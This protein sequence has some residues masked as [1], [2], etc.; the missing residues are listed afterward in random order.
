MRHLLGRALCRSRRLRSPDLLCGRRS[1]RLAR[2]FGRSFSRSIPTERPC[3]GRQARGGAYA[4][5]RLGRIFVRLAEQPHE[6]TPPF[7]AVLGHTVGTEAR[8]EPAPKARE[9]LPSP[10][11]EAA[12]VP[13]ARLPVHGESEPLADLVLGFT[14]DEV[15]AE[16]LEDH[17]G[18]VP[19]A[20]VEDVRQDADRLLAA[21]AEEAANRDLGVAAEAEYLPPVDA[22]AHDPESLGATSELATAGAEQWPQ[23]LDA[24]QA[25]AQVQELVDGEDE[26]P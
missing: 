11:A 8:P 24:R 4:C 14:L 7:L 5:V 10:A 13:P 18:G 25:A 22:V 17:R 26:R 3:L 9:E 20:R 12:P 16:R 15:K 1:R 6:A 23:L 21:V 2:N 19:A